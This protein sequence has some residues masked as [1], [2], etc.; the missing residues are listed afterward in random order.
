MAYLK[1]DNVSLRIPLYDPSTLRLFRRGTPARG[2]VGS[3]A[4][5]ETGGVLEIQALTDISLHLKSGD[6]LAL[7]GHNGAGKTT[8]L[9][10]MAGIYPSTSGS[11]ERSG[12][13]YFYGGVSPVNPDASGYENIRLAVRVG[14]LKA[15]SVEE[16]IAEVE[17]FTELGDYLNMP[18][19]VYSAGMWA[20]LSFAMSTMNVP[21]I[22]LV[23]EGIGAG[24]AK[25]AAKVEARVMDY[26]SKVS[27]LVL[28]SHSTDLL[29][30]LC[31]KAALFEAGRMVV[32]GEIDAVI[33]QYE[34][35]VSV[36]SNKAA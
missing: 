8:L 13:V 12:N 15:K 34:T 3:H 24:D 19:R 18:T 30:K 5:V 14:N 23:D 22:L 4:F 32:F 31:N 9:R 21:D 7:I 36:G 17:E 10:Y 27:I 6:R 33:S 26:T 28:A 11:M 35:G 25:F 29:R 16:Y 2:S 1:L 20:R